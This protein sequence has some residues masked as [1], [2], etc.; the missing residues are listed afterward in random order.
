[1]FLFKLDGY[2][3][4]HFWKLNTWMQKRLHL[5]PRNLV[6][7]LCFLTFL[8]YAVHIEAILLEGLSLF[9]VLHC[10]FSACLIVYTTH[11]LLKRDSL[12]IKRSF[13]VSDERRIML[14]RF[15]FGLLD[16]PFIL[17]GLLA[18]PHEAT[19]LHEATSWKAGSRDLEDISWEMM[20]IFQFLT[21]YFGSCIPTY[22]V[23]EEG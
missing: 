1:M 19:Q 20:E 12:L 21:M 23:M 4:M 22:E 5:K 10:V 17:I 18:L 16:L 3:L 13:D 9:K 15:F 14:L 11:L 7:V 8:S 2:I 6:L